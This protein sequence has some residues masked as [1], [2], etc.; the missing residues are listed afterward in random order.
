[1]P[2]TIS[3]NTK[4][5]TITTP[6][7]KLDF[8]TL[9]FCSV[10]KKSGSNTGKIVYWIDYTKNFVRIRKENNKTERICTLEFLTVMELE[11]ELE[12]QA[13]K[14]SLEAKV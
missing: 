6:R 4:K 8:N 3:P 1:M 9:E 12:R 5:Y 2:N 10:L 13:L 7:I 14:F 11:Q